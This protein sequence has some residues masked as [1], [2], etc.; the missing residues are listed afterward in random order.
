MLKL[1]LLLIFSIFGVN[2]RD[3]IFKVIGFGT[4]MK[5]SIGGNIYTMVNEN[6]EQPMFKGKMLN[7]D[8][9]TIQYQ[10]IMDGETEP[11]LR[12]LDASVTKTYNDFFGREKTVFQ[13]E[14]FNSLGTPWTRSIGPTSLFDDSYIPTVHVTGTNAQ[15]FFNRPNSA[16]LEK[17]TIYLKDETYII[18]NVPATAKNIEFDRFQFRI[19]MGD[20]TI[21]GRSL[22]KFRGAGEDPTQLRQDI[23]GNMM[24]AAGVPAIHSNKVRVYINKKPA[25]F[26]TMQEEAPSNSFIKAEFYG[27]PQ[28]E[29]ITPP[30]PMGYAL[31]CSTG[32]DFAYDPNNLNSFG[33]FTAKPG[34]DNSRAIAMGKALSELDTTNASAVEKFNKEWF[35]INTFYKSMSLEYLTGDWD[36]YW[37]FSSNFAVYDDPTESSV[38]T[39]KFYYISQDHDETFGVG[40]MPPHNTVGKEFTKQSYKTLINR[41]FKNDEFDAERRTLVDK[42]I[43]STPQLQ[44][45]FESVL[46][47]IVKKI[48]NPTEFNRRLY[49]MVERYKDEL[50][51]D[52]SITRPYKA[53]NPLT[54]WDYSSFEANLQGPLEGILWGLPQFVEERSKAVAEEFGFSLDESSIIFTKSAA[55]MNNNSF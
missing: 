25:G 48:F 43:S 10:Y 24:V 52:Y 33:P 1:S 53:A 19:D 46:I 27:N 40:L 20:K 55:E 34:E 17:I 36:G 7:I 39:Y 45:N 16:T 41:T 31:D 35:D 51:W 26:Y 22:L 14:Q 47:D 12:T 37:F 13:L 32:S 11:F 42:F 6:V 2:A 30:N 44:S 50:K 8:D 4:E 15:N 18:E 49:S 38:G 29:A 5:L 21:H 54:S 9:N 3:V 23:Y 28:T